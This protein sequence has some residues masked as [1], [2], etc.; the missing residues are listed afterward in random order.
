M[1]VYTLYEEPEVLLFRKI[2]TKK[3]RSFYERIFFLFIF[4]EKKK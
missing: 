2:N 1:N 3:L 4:G